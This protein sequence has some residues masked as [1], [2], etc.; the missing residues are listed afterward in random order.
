MDSEV[1]YDSDPQFIIVY[2]GEWDYRFYF[3]KHTA[4][5]SVRLRTVPFDCNDKVPFVSLP[6]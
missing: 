3:S 4:T 1:N 6:F 5:W 2:W